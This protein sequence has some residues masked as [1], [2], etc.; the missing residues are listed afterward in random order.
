MLLK[1]FVKCEYSE[2]PQSKATFFRGML[3]LSSIIFMAFLIL[4]F[5]MKVLGVMSDTAVSLR[6]SDAAG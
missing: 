3:L 6:C 1:D 5:M 4:K 2:K